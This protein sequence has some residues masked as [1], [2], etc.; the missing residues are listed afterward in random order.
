MV[1]KHIDM[2]GNPEYIQLVRDI[3]ARQR[4]EDRAKHFAFWSGVVIGAAGVV[5]ASVAYDRY[6]TKKNP[7]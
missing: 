6:R 2:R 5:G 4:K 3:E 7:Q 1:T